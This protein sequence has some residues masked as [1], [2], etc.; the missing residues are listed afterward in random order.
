MKRLFLCCIPFFLLISACSTSNEKAEVNVDV[1]HINGEAQGTTYSIKYVGDKKVQKASVDSILRQIDLSLSAWVDGSVI[2]QFNAS[3]SIVVSDG[4]FLNVFFR[5]K[6]ISEQ[7]GGSFQPMIMPLVRAWGFGPEGGRLKEGVELDSLKQL[8]NFNY[9]ISPLEGGDSVRF[10]K[11]DGY[12]M[13]VNGI[14]QGYSVDVV[15][16]YLESFGINSYMTEIGGEVRAK[17]FNENN[18]SW[19]IGIDKPISNQSERQ[20]QA[21]FELDNASLATSGNYRKFYE[22]DGKRYSHTID[23]STAEPVQHQLLSATV[24]APNCTNADA[25]A[26]AFMVMGVDRTIRF[27]KENPQLNLGIYLIF[28]KEGELKSFMSESL[29]QKLEEL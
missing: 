19:R 20:L 10:V 23:P 18:S 9:E 25:F 28:E 14:A 22:I 26:T 16:D 12:Q 6:E 21:I 15:S 1:Q 8:V 11:P 27:V 5:G 24:L 7:T 29:S 13:D 17:G 4:H 3:D 2:N